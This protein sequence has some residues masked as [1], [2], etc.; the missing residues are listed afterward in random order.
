[1]LVLNKDIYYDYYNRS[2][3]EVYDYVTNFEWTYDKMNEIITGKYLDKNLNNTV[4]EGDQFGYI[5]GGSW[6]YFIP[7]VVSGNPPFITRDEDSIPYFSLHEGDRSNQ[8]A[9]K[10]GMLIANE[11]TSLSYG[12]HNLI[13][14][15]TNSECLIASGQRMGSLENPILRQMESDAA[16]LP[17]PLLFSSDE[18]YVTSAHDTTEMGFILTTVKDLE[19]VSTVTEVLNRETANRVIPKYYKESLQLQCVDDEKASAML[20]VIHDNFDNS[21][22]LAYN[23]ALGNRVFD[24]FYTAAESGREF[25]VV[26]ASTQKTINKQLNKLIKEFEK[27]QGI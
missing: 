25:S 9:N 20:D 26:Y 27:K 13:N 16:V 12:D 23:N 5:N 19:F 11:S 1:L 4:D 10:M 21:F 17:Y 8:L 7:F 24:A 6:G 15:F 14:A 18:K 22:I 2:A 3:D